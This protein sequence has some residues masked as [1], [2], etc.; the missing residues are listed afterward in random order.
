MSYQL[1]VYNTTFHMPVHPVNGEHTAHE[2]YRQSEWLRAGQL[3]VQAF[4]S[5]KQIVCAEWERSDKVGLTY[6]DETYEVVPYKTPVIFTWA[7]DPVRA[8]GDWTTVY[9]ESRI[10]YVHS[11]AKKLS[12]LDPTVVYAMIYE[13]GSWNSRDNDPS[14]YYLAGEEITKEAAQYARTA[15]ASPDYALYRLASGNI[16]ADTRT[17]ELPLNPIEG[18]RYS[19]SVAAKLAAGKSGSDFYMV[20]YVGA[21]VP[22]DFTP[23]FLLGGKQKSY[24]DMIAWAKAIIASRKAEQAY[25][26]EKETS[27]TLHVLR[28]WTVSTSNL[29]SVVAVVEGLSD[30]LKT[31]GYAVSHMRSDEKAALYTAANLVA[32]AAAIL[33]GTYS[34]ET[35]ND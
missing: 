9:K 11:R 17:D 25:V 26:V 1:Q 10:N 5:D 14:Y 24:E 33:Q 23:L 15:P 21:H 22:A 34:K 35:D 2:A 32:K 28:R 4:G 31:V 20:T 8:R 29:R 19:S 12:A 16:T 7:E 27:L 18:V 13:Y 30:D 6:S 3:Q